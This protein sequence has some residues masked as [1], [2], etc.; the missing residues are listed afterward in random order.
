MAEDYLA[1]SDEYLDDYL[2]EED[3]EELSES[4]GV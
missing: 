4:I 1:Q 3:L 2:T